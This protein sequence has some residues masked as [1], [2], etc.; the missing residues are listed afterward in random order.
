MNPFNGEGIA[1]A[2]ESGAIAAEVIVQAQARATYAQRELALQRYPKVLKDTY[3]GY[4]S[5]GRRS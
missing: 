4:Y 2:M 5:L 1:Y 3:G